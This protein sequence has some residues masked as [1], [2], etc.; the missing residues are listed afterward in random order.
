MDPA[1]VAVVAAAMV[2]MV[3]PLGM[4]LDMVAGVVAGP[5]DVLG[6]T[7]FR[8]KSRYSTHCTTALK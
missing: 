1:E 3:A 7:F 6:N 4:D 8:T 5:T 2:A